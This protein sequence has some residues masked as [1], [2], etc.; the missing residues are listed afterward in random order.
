MS[1]RLSQRVDLRNSRI[2]DVDAHR[3]M[4][5]AAEILRRLDHQPGVILADEVGMGKT[6]V[7][8]AVAFSVAEQSRRQVVVQVPS[9]VQE[10]WPREWDVFR[11]F[12]VKPGSRIRAA[13]KTAT[14]ADE[15]LK[16]LDD[17]ADRRNHILFV[18]HA[19]LTQRL[20]DPFVRLAIIQ[21][22]MRGRPSLTK[23]KKALPRWAASILGYRG[24]R[25]PGVV[26]ALLKTKPARWRRVYRYHTGTD[27][28][29]EPVPEAVLDAL[30][31]VDH[32][33]L[34]EVLKDIPLRDSKTVADRLRR[35]RKAVTGALSE[36]WKE[37]LGQ[38]SVCRPLLIVDEAHHLKNPW[39]QFSKLLANREDERGAFGGVFRRM[40]FLTATP[41][42][43]GHRELIEILRRFEGIKWRRQ[44]DRAEYLEQLETLEKK[45][46]SAQTAALRLDRAWSKLSPEDL[47]DVA[48][49][50]WWA[51]PGRDELP[52]ALRQAAGHY[53]SAIE[54]IR[55][56][57]KVLRPW[58]I[59]H[60]RGDRDV[61][62]ELNSGAAILGPGHEE[63]RGLQVR[64][65]ATLPFLLAA[66]AQALVAT[67]GRES[68]R[69][70]RVYFAGGLASSFEAYLETRRRK[71]S[72]AID[73]TEIVEEDHR[74][75]HVDWYLRQLD[76]ALPETERDLWVAHPKIDATVQRVLRLWK[77]G[78]KAVVFCFFRATG[79]ALRRHLSRAIEHELI[80]AA[81]G[82]LR[83]HDADAEAV[84]EELDRRAERFFDPDAPV[85][86][87]AHR[88]VEEVFRQALR[89]SG[90]SG[91]CSLA[92]EE[93]RNAV[94]VV[95]RFI[96]TPSFQVR[97]LE[98]G[99]AT[100]EDSFRKAF[101]RK[102]EGQRSLA[103][104]VR[105]FA[106]FV[107]DRVEAEREELLEA[108]DSVQTGSIFARGVDLEEEEDDLAR[109]PLLPN[110]RLVNGATKRDL[111]RRLLLAF[112]TP[113]FPEILVASSVMA[114]GVDLHLHCRHVIHHDLD[115][116]PSVLEQRTGRLDRLGS[117]AEALGKP[118]VVFEPF[119]EG[120]QD[121]RQFLVVKDRERWFNVVMGEKMDLDEWSTERFVGRVPLP[122]EAAMSLAMRLSLRRGR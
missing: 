49:A 16:L 38:M 25:D 82:P 79:R 115:W 54:R 83:L 78:E 86:R 11:E 85:T 108:L 66:R 48:Q 103:E 65:T 116:N 17:P 60:L 19:A 14:R 1:W 74:S 43:L 55:A 3:Q 36:V 53:R 92:D 46:T 102:K 121:E 39:V 24:F 87:V 114:E 58:L 88:K 59:R 70:L 90:R 67:E 21:R 117:K 23:R 109:G 63:G 62:R 47:A 72:E 56:A 40:L 94:D 75:A 27:L 5:T 76:D 91:R 71:L 34:I 69:A 12:C 2:P 51:Y 68:H 98:L 26:W 95:L 41:F 28:G 9:S 20:A 37:Y 120:T 89:D 10:K 80:Q 99:G 101:E 93:V 52:R 32:S 119:L 100:A 15:F 84:K 97:H 22:A 111:R 4:R 110:V 18:T 6:F 112:N 31:K 33:P 81:R 57:E 106:H 7:A 96:R 105:R 61:R 77:S 8:L 73:E 13:H 45:L 64:G 44:S 118:I 35:V 107:A 104:Q 42:Q 29:D 30:G 122:K 113:F 50:D